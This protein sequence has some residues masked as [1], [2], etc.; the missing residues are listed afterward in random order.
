MDG[1]EPIVSSVGTNNEEEEVD[2]CAFVVEVNS[3]GEL[4]GA[5]CF[6]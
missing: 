6:F 1:F 5:A 4:N 3:I 2:L